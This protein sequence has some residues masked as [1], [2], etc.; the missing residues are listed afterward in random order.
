MTDWTLATQGLQDFWQGFAIFVPK[1]ILALV[2]FIIGWIVAAGVGRIIEEILKRVQ[3]DK[4]TQMKKWGK[5]LDKADFDFTPSEFIG[6]LC[7]WIL[8]I[9]SL[10]ISVELIGLSQFSIFL[11]KVVMW[12]P[13]LLVAILIFVAVAIISGFAEKLVRASI[14]GTKVGYG[15]LAGSIAKWAIWIFGIAAILIQLG[16]ASNLILV[17]F[18]GLIYLVTIAG[19]LAFGLGGK[20]VAADI[21]KDLRGKFSGDN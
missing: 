14:H 6:G 4:L 12:L 16:I 11:N 3:L 19:G 5:S 9:V 17:I 8:L 2:I 20:E 15:K 1:L 13:N 7:K 10:S 21:L 18:Q